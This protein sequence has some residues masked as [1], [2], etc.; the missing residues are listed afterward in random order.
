MRRDGSSRITGALEFDDVSGT[1]RT[2]REATGH[3]AKTRG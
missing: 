1:E 3:G 2:P